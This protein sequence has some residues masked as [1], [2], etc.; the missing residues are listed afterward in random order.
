MIWGR[1]KLD[2]LLKKERHERQEALQAAANLFWARF[3]EAA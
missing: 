1:I 2:M 3:V